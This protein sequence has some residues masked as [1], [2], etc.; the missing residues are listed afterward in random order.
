MI[1]DILNIHHLLALLLG[2]LLVTGCGNKSYFSDSEKEDSLDTIPENNDNSGDAQADD[3]DIEIE[4]VASLEEPEVTIEDAPATPAA[5]TEEADV[6][7]SE[8]ELVVAPEEVQ[9]VTQTV[10]GSDTIV[11]EPTDVIFAVD[12]SGSMS[13][14][15]EKLEETLPLFIEMMSKEFPGDSFQM[16]MLS[17][18]ELDLGD[19]GAKDP[20]YH[21]RDLA[22]DS[23]NA[24]EVVYNFVETPANQCVNDQITP[25]G[26]I[27]QNSNKELVIISDDQSDYSMAEFLQLVSSSVFLKDKTG[28]NGFVGLKEDDDDDCGIASIGETYIELAANQDTLGLVQHLCD[29]NYDGLLA[30]LKESIVKKYVQFEFVLDFDADP[31]HP[32]TIKIDGGDALTPEQYTVEGMKLT[33]LEGISADQSLEIIY[34]P[35]K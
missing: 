2:C 15:M 6:E 16:F 35:V 21:P 14:E 10:T 34:S 24:L 31:A 22:V 3:W 27:R 13:E 17:E 12:T 29:E 19:D 8:D 23:S 30:N 20:R 1:R 28:V 32:I 4:P 18:D 7:G 11:S 33:L 9:T 5:Q 25:E 26:C